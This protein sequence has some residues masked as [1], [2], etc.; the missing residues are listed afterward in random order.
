MKPH[1]KR[2]VLYWVTIPLTFTYRALPSLHIVETHRRDMDL[3]ILSQ[4]LKQIEQLVKEEQLSPEHA[5]EAL[6]QSH[7]EEKIKQFHQEE[8]G[9]HLTITISGELTYS[10]ALLEH[11]KP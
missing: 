4:H 10:K 7:L 3:P 8:P 2:H 6:V 9:Y 5:L 11:L 1:S